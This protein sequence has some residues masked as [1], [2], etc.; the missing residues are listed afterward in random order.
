[1]E[2]LLQSLKGV[3]YHP[4]DVTN[5]IARMTSSD[6][7]GIPITEELLERV[8]PAQNIWIVIRSADLEL[9][10]SLPYLALF[11]C[12]G[13]RVQF[14]CANS[15]QEVRTKDYRN[16]LLGEGGII[17]P[18]SL[19]VMLKNHA[20]FFQLYLWLVS[21]GENRKSG[22]NVWRMALSDRILDQLRLIK[23]EQPPTSATQYKFAHA[24][25]ALAQDNPD[26]TLHLPSTSDV[27]T[28]AQIFDAAVQLQLDH[29]VNTKTRGRAS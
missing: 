11:K 5:M 15:A 4:C 10:P 22:A 16:V 9:L 17:L 14:V 20:V 27:P 25:L 26:S 6:E 28:T 13:P 3:R 12:A 8:L 23:E 29:A 24:V 1:M 19:D 7:R 2:D 21:T 18:V